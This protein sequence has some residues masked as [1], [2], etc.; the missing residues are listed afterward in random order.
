MYGGAKNLFYHILID[1]SC[2]ICFGLECTS[3]E[4]RCDDGFCLD[5]DA[6]NNYKPDC[7]DQN[8]DSPYKQRPIEKTSEHIDCYCAPKFCLHDYSNDDGSTDCLGD[9]ILFLYY[10]SL[11]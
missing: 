10:S 3:T 1:D 11:L 6:L 7:I 9:C 2:Y 4:Y 8:K 5:F